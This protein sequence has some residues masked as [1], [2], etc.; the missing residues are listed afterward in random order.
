MNTSRNHLI[1]GA[2]VLGGLLSA[3]A[4]STVS[5]GF[6]NQSKTSDGGAGADGGAAASGGAETDGGS[7]P[8]PTADSTPPKSYSATLS[9]AAELPPSGSSYAG[10][11]SVT[12]SGDGKEL[13]IVVSTNI[14][15]ALVSSVQIQDLDSNTTGPICTLA[16]HT[17]RS[18]AWADADCTLA[19]GQVAHLD[20]GRLLVN[21]DTTAHPSGEIAGVIEPPGMTP[22]T[23]TP[24][25]SD[26]TQYVGTMSGA[27]ETPPTN[28][29]ATGQARLTLNPDATATVEFTSSIPFAQATAAHLHDAAMSGSSICPLMVGNL[30]GMAAAR[31]TC[32]FSPA[33]RADLSAGK[34]YVNLHTT[35]QMN[36]EI[37][38]FLTSGGGG[39]PPPPPGGSNGPPTTTTPPTPKTY[40]L[41]LDPNQVSPP[42]AST[43]QG[44]ATVAFNGTALDISVD[45][46]IPWNRINAVNVYDTANANAI[47]CSLMVGGRSPQASGSCPV[48]GSQLTSL[49][50][51]KLYILVL[52]RRYPSGD[53]AAYVR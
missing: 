3:T 37:A 50:A 33:Q 29:T 38:G 18:T 19:S 7:S 36:G 48:K 25:P 26:P 11:A 47:V 24:P 23:M 12:L 13:R 31:G 21:V 22:P 5:S 39:A 52:T 6:P 42:S 51:G 16:V 35:A 40:Q 44:T 8:Q 9:G 46:D 30:G 10:T 27:Q 32:T 1:L 49:A 15:S 28:S 34:L 17:D 2:V 53:I 20:S 45:T 4:C 41:T 43:A 14:P